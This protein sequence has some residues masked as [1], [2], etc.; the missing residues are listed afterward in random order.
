[1]TTF[2]NNTNIAPE[3]RNAINTRSHIWHPSR[4]RLQ[5]ARPGFATLTIAFSRSSSSRV[6]SV[7]PGGRNA[8]RISFGRQ[9][10]QIPGDTAFLSPL[11]KPARG[12][13]RAPTSCN[14]FASSYLDQLHGAD[15]PAKSFGT[16]P[17]PIDLVILRSVVSQSLRAGL[18]GV[19]RLAGA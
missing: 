15:R 16:K 12:P 6:T 2:L 19:E 10:I 18:R 9:L 4:L 17:V 7:E 14:S 5:H 3:P 1:M 11:H 8:A 13:H